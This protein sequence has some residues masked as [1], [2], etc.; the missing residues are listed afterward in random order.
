MSALAAKG[1]PGARRNPRTALDYRRG[2]RGTPK[3]AVAN[4]D[5]VRANDNSPFFNKRRVGS[6]GRKAT[7]VAIRRA[8]SAALGRVLGLASGP[9][10]LALLAEEIYQWTTESGPLPRDWGN[11]DDRALSFPSNWTVVPVADNPPVFVDG[12]RDAG[13]RWFQQ[14]MTS[15]SVQTVEH[16]GIPW[17]AQELELAD[18]YIVET[19]PA[20]LVAGPVPVGRI[21]NEQWHYDASQDYAGNSVGTRADVQFYKHAS[22]ANPTFTNPPRTATE[23]H[24]FAAPV[25][26]PVPQPFRR[27]GDPA[28]PGTERGEPTREPSAP[29]VP[30]VPP[31]FEVTSGPGRSRSRRPRPRGRSR[32]N[33]G[34]RPNQPRAKPRK[35]ETERKGDIRSKTGQVF[36]MVGS[37]A[38]TFTEYM[39]VVNALYNALPN[40]LKPGYVELHYRD[41]V[42]GELKTYWKR[43]W[44]PDFAE[45]QAAVMRH[46]GDSRLDL[47]KAIR[48]LLE[49]NMTDRAIGQQGR[50][51][52]R[53][54]KAAGL[55]GGRGWQL[56]SW[57]TFSSK[58][59]WDKKERDRIKQER[60]KRDE[61]LAKKKA[62]K[63]RRAAFA[64]S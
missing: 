27:A 23:T 63:K 40:E 34:P 29:P 30:L 57:D 13:P 31:T 6:F 44:K 59:A 49:N 32:S 53:A 41:K 5:Y 61:D 51:S 38:G 62:R 54:S 2:N 46:F 1:Y 22:G 43:R 19:D 18:G 8:G 16:N 37:L 20:A 64:G 26:A 9:L 10:G 58:A 39:D 36:A 17:E 11:A 45:R 21:I 50:Q 15:P 42:T 48:N 4:V 24:T 52:R 3:I 35:R 14:A 60:A 28:S 12:Y 55:P 33:T 47:E 7:K 25:G 56:G